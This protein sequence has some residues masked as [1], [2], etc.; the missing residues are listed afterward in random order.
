[1]ID[2]SEKFILRSSLTSPF[3]RKVRIAAVV[4]GLADRITLEATDAADDT[5]RH[6]N[7][8]GKYPC[9]LRANGEA[10]YDS[11][12]IIEFFQL[13]VGASL[14]LPECGAERIVALTRTRLADGIID[15]GALIIYETRY[16]P[17]GTESEAWLAYQRD[18]IRRAL[19]TFETDPPDPSNTNALSI[20]LACALTFL[21]RRKPVEWRTGFPQLAAWLQAFADHEPAFDLTRAPGDQAMG[22]TKGAALHH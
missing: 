12:V 9:L 21:D 2:T 15:A 11:S 6:Q 7:P 16:H 1:M 19:V 3:V 20:G 8:L 13:I 17:P 4:L 5:L 10:I 22:D 18:K 14:L